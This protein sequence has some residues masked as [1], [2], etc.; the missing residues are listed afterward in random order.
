MQRISQSAGSFVVTVARERNNRA[1]A[2]GWGIE[3]EKR[4]RIDEG[5]ACASLESSAE[6]LAQSS[7]FP[8]KR[9]LSVCQAPRSG[10]MRGSRSA[11]RQSERSTGPQKEWA[12]RRLMAGHENSCLAVPRPISDLPH[13]STPE[14]QNLKALIA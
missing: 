13:P 1:A 4:R 3:T 8:P 5:L 9:A 2:G 14:V 7:L 6:S 10:A 11:G 12:E